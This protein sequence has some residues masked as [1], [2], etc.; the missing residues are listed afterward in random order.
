MNLPSQKGSAECRAFFLSRIYGGFP[1]FPLG[2]H[3]RIILRIII[4]VNLF[5][6]ASFFF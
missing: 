4:I 3:Y 1:S 2:L 5:F 6:F